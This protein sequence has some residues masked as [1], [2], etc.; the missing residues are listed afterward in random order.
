MTNDMQRIDLIVGWTGGECLDHGGSCL[1]VCLTHSVLCV[2]V[3]VCVCVVERGDF[4]RLPGYRKS[5]LSV[6]LAIHATDAQ[7]GLC[8]YKRSGIIRE[9]NVNERLRRLNERQ[10]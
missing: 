5:S 3:C 8:N 6:S 2:C 10:P 1:E 9:R 7:V 4:V